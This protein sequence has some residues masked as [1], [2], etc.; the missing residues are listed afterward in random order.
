[1]FNAEAEPER[2]VM[3]EASMIPVVFASRVFNTA[4]SMDVSEI[5]IAS[6]PNPSIPD[7]E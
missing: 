6:F 4:A 1:M 3:V 7:E 2:V 5:V